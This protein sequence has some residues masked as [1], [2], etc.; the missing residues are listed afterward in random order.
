MKKTGLRQRGLRN[1]WYVAQLYLRYSIDIHWATTA[2]SSCHL[3][4]PICMRD[5]ACSFFCQIHTAT[6][7]KRLLTELELNSGEYPQLFIHL[8]S[9]LFV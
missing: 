4:I 6:V 3:T 5:E 7:Y 1:D 9:V 8:G 2:W